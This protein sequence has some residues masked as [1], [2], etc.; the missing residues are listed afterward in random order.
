VD[1]SRRPELAARARRP[2]WL[3]HP[4]ESDCSPYPPRRLSRSAAAP[5]A[6][7]RLLDH[8]D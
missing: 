4:G 7:R 6:L 2:E 1:R 5:R 3:T 8:S